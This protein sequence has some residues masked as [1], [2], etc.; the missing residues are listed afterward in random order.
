MKVG[1]GVPYRIIDFLVETVLVISLVGEISAVISDVIARTFFHMSFLWADE[2]AKLA[3]SSLTFIGGA[4]AYRRREHAFVRA[5]INNL[6][7]RVLNACL[8][9]SDVVVIL[10]SAVAAVA[11]LPFLEIGWMQVTPALNMPVAWTVVPLTGSMLLVIAYAAE[12]LW[13]TNRAT[14]LLATPL[15]FLLIAVAS[16][17]R[18]AWL[19]LFTG[20]R[21]IIIA[22]LLF[23]VSVLMG[24]PVGFGLLLS[25]ASYLWLADTSPMVALPQNM[26]AGTSNFVLLALPFFVL[27][28][29]VMERGG[30]S[31][32]LVHF[33]HALVGHLRSGLLQVMVVSMYL[34]SGLLA[35]KV[36]TSRRSAPSCAGC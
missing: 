18:D 22:V 23:L 21:A 3:L 30:I 19:P 31:F 20:D 28:G 36:P 34:V 24:L 14:A 2:I 29:L 7:P 11:S 10:I 5:L 15:I 33:V 17:F 1:G 9:S 6:S 26:L 16:H 13:R 8:V 4:Y 25:T 27:A 12:H 32:R 35:Q